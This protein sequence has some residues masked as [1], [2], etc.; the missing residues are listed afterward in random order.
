MSTTY[1]TSLKLALM[2]TGDQSGTW[3][4]TTNT[5]IGTLLEQA[6]TGVGAVSL[7]GL[8]TYT[9]TNFNGT[10]D[11]QRNAVLV[12]TGTPSSTVT[13]V[14]PLVNKLYTV[15]NLTG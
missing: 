7:T 5:N 2:G 6:I 4:Q 9:L 8:T 10:L 12:F 1:S 3:G 11:D 13:I 15:V 14:A